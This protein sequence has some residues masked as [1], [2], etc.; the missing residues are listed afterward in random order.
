M[1]A[2]DAK[3]FKSEALS[4]NIIIAFGLADKDL[5]A[6]VFEI[7]AIFALK[8]CAIAQPVS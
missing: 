8:N 4:R 6:A 2:K 1:N 7:F 5:R 3:I